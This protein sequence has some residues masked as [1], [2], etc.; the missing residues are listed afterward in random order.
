VSYAAYRQ[1]KI[2]SGLCYQ[3]FVVDLLLQTLGLAVVQYSSK[4]YQHTVGESR[5]G[6]EIK[7]DEIYAKSRRLW[8]EIAE[9]AMPRPGPYVPSGIMR[10][11]NTW[12][13]VIGDYDTV[14]IFGKVTLRALHAS[15]RF[16]I[17]EN[18]SGTSQ[19]FYLADDVAQRVAL[20]VLTPHAEQKVSKAIRDLQALGRALHRIALGEPAPMS[21]FGPEE[22]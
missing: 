22:L 21:L 4:F 3:D 18:H 10:D 13:Y 7:H 6:V 16:A 1:T 14:F 19:A 12:L 5:T 17:V 15:K 8:I 2:E 9:K 11:D 20:C